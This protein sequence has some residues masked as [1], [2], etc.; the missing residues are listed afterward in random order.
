MQAGKRLIR[1]SI[2]LGTGLIV[3]GL[4]FLF[5]KPVL[6]ALIGTGTVF[7]FLTYHYRTFHLLHKT[8]DA[9]LGTLFYPVGVLTAFILLYNMPLGFFR[10]SLLLLTLSDTVAN[11][12]GHIRP[13]NRYFSLFKKEEKS[14]YGVLGF[15]GTTLL[16]FS[17]LL[18]D[19]YFGWHAYVI[20]AIMLAAIFEIVS[21]RGSDNF[22][23][24]VGTALF[25][26]IM[27]TSENNLY[28]LIPVFLVAATGSY[29][30][31]RM[32]LLTR[33]GAILVFFLGIYFFGVLGLAWTVPVLLFFFSSVLLT[34]ISTALR[35]KSRSSNR[36]N[37]WQVLANIFWALLTS[38]AF[39]ITRQDIFIY[40]YITLLAAVTADT[41][42]SE[43][44]PVFHKRCLSLRDFRLH[45][46]GI[47]GGISTAGTIASLAGSLLISL[48]GYY[49]FFGTLDSTT[50]VW[51]T[52][53]G[54]VAGFADTLLG[55]FLE[56]KLERVPLLKQP[57][58]EEAETPS[59]NDVVNLMG[60]LAAPVS[61]WLFTELFSGVI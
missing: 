16:I 31:Y 10:I 24:P 33:N 40:L 50:I 27:E 49:L 12:T 52:L 56:N 58:A 28:F 5:E 13:G 53:A 44:G 4:T 34:R 3:L 41:W 15:A 19:F 21:F 29:L 32:A 18:P 11:I 17:I 61:F 55:T 39:L 22:S 8:S 9:S 46:S 26:L 20:L 25:F 30:L 2:H 36:R 37:A 23:I 38:S 6:L 54:F 48:T 60:S 57:S 1:K 43:A 47:S 35:G 51:L 59:P 45:E 7:A 42:S 14:L